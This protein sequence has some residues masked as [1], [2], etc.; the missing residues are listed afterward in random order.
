MPKFPLTSETES[1]V[2]QILDATRD[3]VTQF[4]NDPTEEHARSLEKLEAALQTAQEHIDVIYPHLEHK[5]AHDVLNCF[6]SPPTEIS[7]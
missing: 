1:S 4:M 5:A 2:Y 7:H 6:P 3:H